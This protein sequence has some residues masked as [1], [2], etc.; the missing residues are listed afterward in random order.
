MSAAKARAR[1]TF[2]LSGTDIHSRTA[3]A[4]APVWR[5]PLAAIHMQARSS[6]HR[7]PCVLSD[8]L[9]HRRVE[10]C[11][12]DK[13]SSEVAKHTP[14]HKGRYIDSAGGHERPSICAP[15]AR[16]F[17][18]ARPPSRPHAESGLW[19]RPGHAHL[20]RVITSGEVRDA[21]RA[22]ELAKVLGGHLP[23]ERTKRRIRRWAPQAGG[24]W[25]QRFPEAHAL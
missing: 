16:A 17:S 4:L 3:R 14:A 6:A 18:Q 21:P 15:A 24:G 2:V 9:S 19:F 8:I 22:R 5:G 23:P 7:A 13:E 12:V 1:P 10:V 25:A 11:H 20:A